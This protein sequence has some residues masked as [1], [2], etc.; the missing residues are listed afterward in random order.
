MGSMAPQS[1]LSVICTLQGGGGQSGRDAGGRAGLG[2]VVLNRDILESL[3]G[4]VTA[5]QNPAQR[6]GWETGVYP[7]EDHSITK[8]SKLEGEE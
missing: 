5:E 8:P 7:R 2:G 3:R 6:L 1:T 4:K